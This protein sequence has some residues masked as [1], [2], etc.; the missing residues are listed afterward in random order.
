MYRGCEWIVVVVFMYRKQELESHE[1]SGNEDSGDL[2]EEEEEE[3]VR[4][5][6]S[7]RSPS[8]WEGLS[9]VHTSSIYHIPLGFIHNCKQTIHI[10]FI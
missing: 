5:A 1:R 9:F 3:E 10:D 7:G 2:S 4:T 8:Q 6:W